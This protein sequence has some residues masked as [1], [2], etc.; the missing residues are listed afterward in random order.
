MNENAFRYRGFT[1]RPNSSRLNQGGWNSEF[2]ITYDDGDGL[3]VKHYHPDQIHSDKESAV[4]YCIF[5][6]KKIIDEIIN[7]GRSFK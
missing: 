4:E 6:G 1:I 3:E 7:N 5:C 2:F